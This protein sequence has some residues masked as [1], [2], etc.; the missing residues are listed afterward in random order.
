[1]ARLRQTHRLQQ[2]QRLVQATAP[3]E[4][5]AGDQLHGERQRLEHLRLS[6]VM[7]RVAESPHHS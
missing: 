6:G 5:P 7:K 4:N 2:F 3:V 1:M